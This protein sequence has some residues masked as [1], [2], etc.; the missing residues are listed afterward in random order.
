[1]KW[2]FPLLLLF[3]FFNMQYYIYL[4]NPFALQLSV[5]ARNLV[6]APETRSDDGDTLGL[7]AILWRAAMIMADFLYRNEF[8]LKQGPSCFT[9]IPWYIWG[10]FFSPELHTNL[11]TNFT[12]N[13]R[14]W[15]LSF[16]IKVIFIP[17]RC[18]TS[19]YSFL[20]LYIF[21]S[22]IMQSE[23]VQIILSCLEGD[24]YIYI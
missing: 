17:L 22:F 24:I 13:G 2:S 11:W 6:N 20:Y 1:V 15:P 12:S 5:R 4:T 8:Y 19:I 10:F 16:C 3:Y 21:F 7:A 18:F 23:F 14:F 9:N